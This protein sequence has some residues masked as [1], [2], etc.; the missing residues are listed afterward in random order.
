MW[1]AEEGEALRTW[2]PG[3]KNTIPG[4]DDMDSTLKGLL[5]E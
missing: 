2:Q 5:E 4:I 3:A 1:K